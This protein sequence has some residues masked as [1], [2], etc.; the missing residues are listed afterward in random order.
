MTVDNFISEWN[1]DTSPYVCVHTSGSTGKPKAMQ[2]EKEKMV[3]SARVTCD[4][5]G[6]EAGDT[7]LLCLPLDYIAGKMMVVRALVRGLNL[8]TVEPSGHPLAGLAVAPVF[9]AMTPMQVYN[10]MQNEKE[11][12]LLMAVR[13]LIIG[14][15]TVDKALENMLSVFPNNVWSTYGMTE[16]LSHIA[17]RR[18]SGGEAD[19][20]YS[21]FDNV[22][23]SIA[24]DGCLVIYAPYV[25]ESPLKT[26]DL[27]EISKDDGRRFRI[28]GRKDNVICSGG[29]K[30]QIEEVEHLLKSEIKV[31]FAITKKTDGKYGEIVVLIAEQTDETVLR[32]ICERLLPKFWR[33]RL[34]ISVPSIPFT[35]T[36][37][38]ARGN[39]HEI[40]EAY[41]R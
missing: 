30:I 7:A 27:A 34:Y 6:L 2:V 14:G 17:V 38:P 1:D 15:G 24:E 36:G 10:S 28:L 8:V 31:P 19:S 41:H 23:V 26:N 9:A 3:N 4:F 5:L 35:E 11:R 18:L 20:W 39:I 16:T 25:C 13:H 22:E 32:D 33:P 29:I 40:A 12:K 21:P 37:K